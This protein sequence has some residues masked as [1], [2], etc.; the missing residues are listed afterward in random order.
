MNNFVDTTSNL[1]KIIR[2]VTTYMWI[3][4]GALFACYLYF[5]GSI[6]FS[7][8]KQKDIQSDIKLLISSI[9]KQELVYLQNQKKLTEEYANSLGLQSAKQITFSAP[10][11]AFAWNV[12]Y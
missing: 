5:I 3:S 8:V 4:T 1:N 11:K 12:G 6:T 10:K 7:V 9:G 2:N